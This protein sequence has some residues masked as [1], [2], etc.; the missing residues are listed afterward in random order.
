MSTSN[1]LLALGGLGLGAAVGAGLYALL[2]KPTTV[3]VPVTKVEV[4]EKELS[5]EDLELLCSSTVQDDRGRLEDA[6]KEVLDLRAQ[7]EAREK[8]LATAKAAV[9]KDATRR[10][11]AAKKWK[12]MEA[13]IEQLKT[14]LVQVEEERD[15]LTV[16][17]K[18]TVKE[19]QSQIKETARQRTRA[20]TYK[21]ESHHNLWTTFEADAKVQIC[22]W[23][24]RRR[25]EKCH[26][27]VDSAIANFEDRFLECVDTF[28]ATPTLVQAEG[29]KAVLPV[30]AAWLSEDD[31]FTRKGW[32]VQFCDPS[33]PE[34]GGAAS[35]RA[36]LAAPE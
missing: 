1:T 14:Q 25:H 18:E 7:L 11:A 12:E 29:R 30:N 5:A 19:L 16:Q 17:L 2:A 24:S 36:E 31:R 8:T 15:A 23:G 28:Q 10:A 3:E 21:K 35:D 27:A 32:Y 4:I 6:Q 26:E 13:E 22:D 9:E 20:E 33:L 34:A